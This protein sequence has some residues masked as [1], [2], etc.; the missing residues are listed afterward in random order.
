MAAT[1]PAPIEGTIGSRI[2]IVLGDT[3]DEWLLLLNEDDGDRQWQTHCW[4]SIPNKLAAQLNNCSK[5]G[6]YAKEVAFGPTGA[7]FV[8]GIKRDGT[9]NHSWWGDASDACSDV[10]KESSAGSDSIKVS[11][12]SGSYYGSEACVVLVGSNGYWHSGDNDNLISR[13]KRIH[14]RRKKIHFVRLFSDDGYFISDDEGTEWQ[15]VGDHCSKA[16]KQG[17]GGAVEEVGVAADGSWVVIRSNTFVSST[18][19][20][21][22][23]SSHISDFF[24]R[25][26]SRMKQRKRAIVE[27]HKQREREA[28]QEAQRQ[29]QQAEEQARI[30][31]CA[32][33]RAAAAAQVALLALEK[34]KKAERER[35]ARLLAEQT[36]ATAG[37]VSE[38]MEEAQCIQEAEEHLSHRKRALKHSCLSLP[39]AQRV[40]VETRAKTQTIPA[41]RPP[42]AEVECVVCQDRVAERAVVPC[43]HHCLCD[44]CAVQLMSK[45]GGK[46][47]LCRGIVQSTLKIF[48]HG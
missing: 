16:L 43:G 8:N 33:L 11:F 32:G 41:E 47:P 48:S 27:F 26:R 5:K 19:L 10:I 40:R 28:R 13:M 31:Q 29:L 37:L 42:A 30:D 38:L 20:A 22:S 39:P 9:G 14:N 24:Q 2:R 21:A 25:Q 35:A 15:S 6:R 23:L 17:S 3:G 12:G 44:K 7:W 18:G 1:P 45:G 46:C 4:S 34:K 36:A